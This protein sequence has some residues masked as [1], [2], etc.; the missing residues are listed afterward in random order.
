MLR[1]RKANPGAEKPPEPDT[2]NTGVGKNYLSFFAHR[3]SGAHF[4][5]EEKIMDSKK[6]SYVFLADGFEEIEALTVVDLLRRAGIEV[7]KYEEA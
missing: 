2:D 1:R 4:F 6:T 7:V 3:I 5:K